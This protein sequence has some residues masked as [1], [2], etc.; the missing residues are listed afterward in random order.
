GKFSMPGSQGV[1]AWCDLSTGA[2][3]PVA[4][5]P[6][7][8]ALR[9]RGVHAL[10]PDGKWI[11]FAEHRD[12]EGEQSGNQG[13]QAL[14]RRLPAEGGTPESITEW[15]ARI[16]GICADTQGQGVFIATDLGV[17]HNDVWHVPF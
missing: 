10:S 2:I 5:V 14:L 13:P 8:W 9:L 1:I 4:G 3:T 17:P 12:R 6:D 7:S 15:P 16:Y 11:Y